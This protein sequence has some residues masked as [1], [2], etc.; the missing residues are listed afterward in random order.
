MRYM[1]DTAVN[2]RLHTNKYDNKNC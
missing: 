1:V 2:R